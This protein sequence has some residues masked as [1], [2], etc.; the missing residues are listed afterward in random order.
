MESVTRGSRGNVTKMNN[1][2]YHT[3]VDKSEYARY[4]SEIVNSRKQAG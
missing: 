2:H 4:T 3:P 1:N